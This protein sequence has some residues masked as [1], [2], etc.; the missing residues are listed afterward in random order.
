MYFILIFGGGAFLMIG[1]LIYFFIK[2]AGGIGQEVGNIIE[3]SQEDNMGE[4]KPIK[5]EIKNPQIDTSKITP[6]VGEEVKKFEFRPRN[7]K[8]FIAQDQSKEQAKTIIK[9]SQRGIKGH[10]FLSARQ[11]TGKT[12]FIQILAKELDAKLI[13]R[14]GKQ[15]DEPDELV[16]VINEINTCPEKNVIFFCDEMDSMDKKIIKMLNPI[17]EEFKISGLA[18][19]PFIFAGASISKDILIKNNPDTMD[20]ISHHINFSPYSIDDIKKILIQYKNQLYPEDK[21]NNKE[22]D[23]IAS[24]C[25]FCPRIGISLLEDF[26]VEKDIQKVLHNRR[27]VKD[28]LT[29]IDIKIL[30]VLSKAK[31][32]MGCNAVALRSGLTQR[33]YEQEFEPF[34]YSAHYINRTPSREIS[35]KG[36]QFLKEISH[37]RTL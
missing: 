23:T 18:I 9:K 19:K 2:L 28:G 16:N 36:R 33:Q 17:I 37:D 3:D 27:I 12:T 30:Q 11:G 8:E 7:F 6:Y 13:T 34:L 21:I 14:V 29:E 10:L 1:G 15:L 35:E 25:K 24:S 22:L 31:R 26:I 32:P 4:K 20:R 5:V